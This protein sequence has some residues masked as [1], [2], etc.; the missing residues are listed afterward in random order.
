V[1]GRF[2]AK[3]EGKTANLTPR[4]VTKLPLRCSNRGKVP[5]QHAAKPAKKPMQQAVLLPSAGQ[6][7]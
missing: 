7:S 2:P 3:H 5:R 4:N 1:Y 6:N